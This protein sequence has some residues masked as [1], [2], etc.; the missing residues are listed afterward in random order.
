[1]AINSITKDLYPV[2]ANPYNLLT[3][4]ENSQV[5]FPVLDLKDAFFCLPVATERQKLFAF[6]WENPNTVRKTHLTWTVLPQGFKNRPTIFGNQLA[7][8]LEAWKTPSGKGDTVAILSLI[9]I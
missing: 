1:M 7:C 3:K 8:D 5:W 6:E 9:H 4:L 2:V